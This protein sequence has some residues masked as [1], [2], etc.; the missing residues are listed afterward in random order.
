VDKRKNYQLRMRLFIVLFL[1]LTVVVLTRAY[2]VYTVAGNGTMGYTGDN[3]LAIDAELNNP[4]GI[5]ISPSGNIY[6]A[7]SMNNV[8][9]M[10]FPNGTIITVAGNGTMGYSGDGGPAI[11]AMLYNPYDV[12]LSS[13]GNMYIADTMNNVIRMVQWDIRVMVDLPQMLC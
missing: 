11:K 4:W 10:V 6:I 12:A 2:Y 9:R 7:D 5:A 1:L 13:A 3:G 8:I